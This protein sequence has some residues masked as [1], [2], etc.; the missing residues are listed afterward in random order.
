MIDELNRLKNILND[1]GYLNIYL[2]MYLKNTQKNDNLENI[3]LY[4]QN[5]LDVWLRKGHRI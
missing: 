1:L 3:Q 4:I 5:N 2:S